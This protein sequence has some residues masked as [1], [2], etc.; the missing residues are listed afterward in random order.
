MYLNPPTYI[1]LISWSTVSCWF[2]IMICN[3]AIKKHVLLLANMLDPFAHGLHADVSL[4]CFFFQQEM[5]DVFKSQCHKRNGQSAARNQ[6]VMY[7]LGRFAKH[8]RSVRVPH[9]NSQVR[10]LSFFYAWQPP[11]LIHH[12]MVVHCMLTI[13]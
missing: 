10:L 6:Q 1:T 9:G 13:S 2:D 4:F 8:K 3:K 5:I 11:T 12:L 7:A